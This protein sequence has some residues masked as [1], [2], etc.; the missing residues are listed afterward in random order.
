[1]SQRI[2]VFENDAA[3]ADEVKSNFERMGL[4]V[5]VAS[6][7]PSGLELAAV[8]RP[9]LI[10]L[11]IELPGMNGF[12]VCKKIKKT[13]EL[14]SV[15][16]VILSSEVDQ[17]TFEQHKKLR[18]RADEYIRKPIAFR[19]LLDR[20]QSFVPNG[21]GVAVD[22]A[23]ETA[24]DIEEAFSVVDDDVIVLADDD[25]PDEI[26]EPD[27]P[28][29]Y[30]GEA[31]G[32]GFGERHE[33]SEVTQQVV[34]PAPV[35]AVFSVPATVIPA[36]AAEVAAPLTETPPLVREA[37]VEVREP[38]APP[39]TAVTM[40]A[41]Q[42]AFRGQSGP[43]D[44]SGAGLAQSAELERMKRELAAADEKVQAAEK[45]ASLAD[46]RATNAEKSLDAAKRTG[47]ASSRELLDLREQLNRKERELLD[48]RE[49]VTGRDKQ[50]IEASERGLMVERELQDTRDKGSDLQR[51]LEKKTEVV[52]ALTT[53]KENVRKRLDDAKARAERGEAKVKELG[54]E[55]DGLK[56]R[57]QL[58][59]EEVRAQQAQAGSAL[60]AEHAAELHA[61]QQKY[62][63]EL[64]ALRQTSATELEA[65]KHSSA[66]E[67]DALKQKSALEL[68]TLQ[69][70]QAARLADSARAHAD[71]LSELRE[72][73]AVTHKAAVEHHEQDKRSALES[74]RR[75]LDEMQQQKLSDAAALHRSELASMREELTRRHAT[76]QTEFADKHRQELGRLGKL[77][78]EAESRHALLEE[79]HEDTEAARATAE[80]QL[81]AATQERDEQSRRNALL[82]AELERAKAKLAHDEEILE[83]VRKAMAIGL[84]LLEEQK[85]SP[86]A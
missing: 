48:L 10:L 20:V 4:L 45:R 59:L 78:S 76:E 64:D 25:T 67:L 14:E 51:E 5:D 73:H 13:I 47:G 19:D 32:F 38:V 42:T 7:G 50:L 70:Q 68:E 17:E 26:L 36:F 53:D 52:V 79:R 62:T 69:K 56:A 81:R 66:I 72:E 46:Q 77:L 41:P 58:E 39:R 21:N 11:T 35:A 74:L 75:E 2:L 15:P 22:A 43:V 37:A 31:S 54:T 3:F 80:T 6:D 65:L 84:G 57:H 60:R 49:Q 9:D 28:A 85:Q 27:E 83:R 55:L 8:H 16:L 63:V 24:L 33:H 44:L 40:S 82:S 23:E 34:E 71:E 61:L 30:G 29:A 86:E 12:L 1:M 18:T